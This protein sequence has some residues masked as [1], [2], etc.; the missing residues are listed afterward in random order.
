M[1][2]SRRKTAELAPPKR[3]SDLTLDELDA[4]ILRFLRN[5][6]DETVDL[7][8]LAEE[9]GVIPAKMQIEVERLGQRGMVVVPFIEPSEAGGGTLTEVGLQWLIEFEGGKPKDVPVAYRIAKEH[10]RASDEAARLPRAQVYGVK[11]RS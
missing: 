6:P 2:P 11:P 4:A 10:V 8:P 3:G 1:R 7:M 9:L 5:F